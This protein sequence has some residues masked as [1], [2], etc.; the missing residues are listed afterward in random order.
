VQELTSGYASFEYEQTGY[1]TTDLVKVRKEIRLFLVLFLFVF[2]L[3][4][5]ILLNGVSAD[6]LASLVSKKT[7]ILF[8]FVLCCVCAFF[9]FFERFIVRM[10][11][12]TE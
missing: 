3:Q 8:C 5:D 10:R 4:V 9:F 7:N 1:Q 6:P 12:I 2:V 11:A